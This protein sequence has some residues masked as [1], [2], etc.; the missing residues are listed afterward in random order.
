MQWDY[1]IF[2]NEG[3]KATSPEKA[4]NME[5]WP[6]SAV[7]CE[8]LEDKRIVLQANV[9]NCRVCLVNKNVFQMAILNPS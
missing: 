2:V 5:L 3:P 4:A 6:E 8:C 9:I 7:T 1:R